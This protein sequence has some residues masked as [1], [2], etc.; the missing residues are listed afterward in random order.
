LNRIT[1]K[2]FK[3]AF[4]TFGHDPASEGIRRLDPLVEQY[5]STVAAATDTELFTLPLDQL[6]AKYSFELG[7][8]TDTPLPS[9]A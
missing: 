7:Q 9:K 4:E 5:Q 8:V 3:H 2:E 1:L 6:F